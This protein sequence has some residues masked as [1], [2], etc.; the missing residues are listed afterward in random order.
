HDMRHHFASRLA[1][2]GVDLN[3][4]RELLGHSD[5]TMTLRYAHLAPEFNLKAVEVLDDA[6]EAATNGAK[7]LSIVR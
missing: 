5:Y 1:M 6:R 7:V 2:G 3:T 4:I